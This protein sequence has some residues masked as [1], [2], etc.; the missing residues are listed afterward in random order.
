MPVGEKAGIKMPTSNRMGTK[1]DPVTITG[2]QHTLFPTGDNNKREK[3]ISLK[4]QIT[5]I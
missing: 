3:N 2:R 1:Y 5:S 4:Q